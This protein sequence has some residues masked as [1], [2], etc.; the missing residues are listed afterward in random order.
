MLQTL[1]Q[2]R[3]FGKEDIIRKKRI[4]QA[5]NLEKNIKLLKKRC[6]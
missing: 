3:G 1:S 4:R 6:F 5:Q 2:K